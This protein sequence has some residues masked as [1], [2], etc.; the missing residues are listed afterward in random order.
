[1]SAKN[2]KPRNVNTQYLRHS[3]YIALLFQISWVIAGLLVAISGVEV[4]WGL[5]LA[6]LLTL[7]VPALFTLVTRIELSDGF[8]IGY[9]AFITGASLVGSA[10]GGYGSIPNWDTIVHIYS[11]TLLAWFGFVVANHAEKSINTPLP[12]WLKNVVAFMTPLAFAAAWEIYEYA[13][14]VLLGTSMQAGGLEDT[15]VDMLAALL[16][17]VVA[18]IVSSAWFS[19]HKGIGK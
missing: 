9:A 15:I 4:K 18:L 13:S 19:H 12:L 10:L 5:L 8:Q 14:D 17:A 7:W 1:M 16:G 3:L 6:N 2:S 11:G